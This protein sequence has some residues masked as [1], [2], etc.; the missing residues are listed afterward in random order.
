MK[1]HDAPPTIAIIGGGFCGTMVAVHLLQQSQPVRIVLINSRYPLSKGIA[2]SSYS[3]KHLLNVPAKNMGAFPEDPGHFVKWLKNHENYGVLDLHELPDMY[4]PRNI[5]GQYLKDIF[6][7]AIRKKNQ[8]VAIEFVHDMAIDLFKLNDGY[9]V[10]FSVSPPIK[11][12]KVVLAMGNHTPRDP[13]FGNP[14]FAGS[15]RYFSNPWLKEAVN[16]PENEKNILI[17][18]NGLTMVDVVLGLRE[19]GF[20][21]KIYSLSPHG[22]KILPHRKFESY[23][24]MVDELQKPYKLHELVSLFRK[25][26]AALR[27]ENRSAEAIVDSFRPLTQHIWKEL[28]T[29][30]KQRFLFH[31]RHLWGVARHRL[32]MNIH[33]E[34]Q[35]LILDDKLEIIAGKIELAIDNESSAEIRIRRRYKNETLQ[36]FVD[37]VIN[38]TG[39]ESNLNKMSDPLIQNLLNARLIQADELHLGINA[40]ENGQV[41]SESSLP[42]ENLLTLGTW[43]K[44]ILWESTAIPELRIQAKTIADQL[45]ME[46]A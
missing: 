33:K 14:Q 36:L 46:Y 25:H 19:N 17:I 16:H 15:R 8:H 9:Q 28:S 13:Y 32:P 34:I 40:T 29:R 3:N 35:Q 5:Y 22:F 2:Y 37:R 42:D 21:G 44:G 43:L 26:V 1:N 10:H 20:T 4:L 6:E 30:E 39:P 45:T 27:T 11:A 38:C 18:G 7:N 24:K 41:I 23:R 12:N 31:L